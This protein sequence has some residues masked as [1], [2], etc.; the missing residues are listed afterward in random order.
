MRF[1]F[2]FIFGLSLLC[3]CTITLLS[4][5]PIFSTTALLEDYAFRFYFSISLFGWGC[6]WY[7]LAV[8]RD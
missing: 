7:F 5:L 3:L 1:V 4:C 6:G 8:A 2:C